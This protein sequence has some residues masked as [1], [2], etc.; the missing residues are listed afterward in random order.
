[1]RLRFTRIPSAVWPVGCG[2][3]AYIGARASAGIVT[4]GWAALALVA[5]AYAFFYAM[6]TRYRCRAEAAALEREMGDER[7]AL[8]M[9]RRAPWVLLT[10]AEKDGTLYQQ[11]LAQVLTDVTPEGRTMV[12]DEP[13]AALLYYAEPHEMGEHDGG[14]S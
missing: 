2:I 12:W 6:H 4:A 9:G 14:S 11:T 3:S 8:S 10:V 5:M 13:A 7:A 1:M